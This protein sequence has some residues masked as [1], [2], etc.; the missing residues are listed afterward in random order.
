MSTDVSTEAQYRDWA[1]ALADDRLPE[2]WDHLTTTVNA[3]L[4]KHASEGLLFKE[5]KRA[6]PAQRML[7]PLRGSTVRRAISNGDALRRAGFGAP[8]IIFHGTLPGRGEFLFSRPGPGNDLN[9]WLARHREDTAFRRQMLAALG[10]YIGRLHG[11]GFVHGELRAESIYVIFT[12]E[13][14][15][16]TLANNEQNRRI[17]PVPG[18]LMLRNLRQ[19]SALDRGRLGVT[20][21][22]RFFMA[23]RRQLPH[24]A[25]GEAR[26]LVREV[27]GD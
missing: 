4:A 24:L 5:F 9:E 8:D 22:T 27:I 2:G 15:N 11:S 25:E 10:A 16:F 13:N 3:R 7:A 14:F 23:W 21:R 18:T 17:Q 12:G 20:D 6:T 1:H 26:L 19:L